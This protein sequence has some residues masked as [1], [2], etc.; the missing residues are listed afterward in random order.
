MWYSDAVAIVYVLVIIPNVIIQRLIKIK[1]L[2][3]KKILFIKR[4]Q[5]KTMYRNLKANDLQRKQYQ[6][7]PAWELM[8]FT[9]FLFRKIKILNEI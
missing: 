8:R 3:L 5:K 6:T 2:L 1:I 4:F 7:P 9:I